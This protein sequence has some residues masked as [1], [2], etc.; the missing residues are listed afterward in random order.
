MAGRWDTPGFPHK[1]WTHCY[2]EDLGAPTHCCEMCG[3]ERVRFAHRMQHH[4]FPGALLVGRTCAAKMTDP[5][6]T[7]A[8]V[9]GEREDQLRARAGRRRTWTSRGW[10]PSI[11]R[12][13]AKRVVV[14]K[15][16]F[17]V[18][19]DPEGFRAHVIDQVT[20]EVFGGGKVFPNWQQ[21]V[22]AMFDW[23][24]PA[25]TKESER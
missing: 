12:P 14:D 2:V 5:Y 11:F 22:L 10:E 23:C 20:G 17:V 24:W 15:K 7:T 25:R 6:Y 1:G 8:Q 21:A 13:G 9:V 3:M 4:T 19:P 16:E 18:S